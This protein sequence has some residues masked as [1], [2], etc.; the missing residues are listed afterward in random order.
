MASSLGLLLIGQRGSRR[1]GELASWR[2]GEQT[3]GVEQQERLPLPAIRVS[4]VLTAL[5]R[6]A[7]TARWWRVCAERFIMRMDEQ[8]TGR[9]TLRH[10]QEA[11]AE[12]EEALQWAS[13]EQDHE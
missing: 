5:G 12:E 10:T 1:D 3:G 8:S 13:K 2:A 11:E 7:K 6:R 4:S 9:E